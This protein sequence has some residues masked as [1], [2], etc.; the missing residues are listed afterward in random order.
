[1]ASLY[2]EPEPKHMAFLHSV[3]ASL[4]PGNFMS[5]LM[6]P[7]KSSISSSSS[8]MMMM[9]NL[10]M[11]TSW[12]L[13]QPVEQKPTPAQ[14]LEAAMRGLQGGGGAN[15]NQN[16]NAIKTNEDTFRRYLDMKTPGTAE[17]VYETELFREWRMWHDLPG[18]DLESSSSSSSSLWITG[19]AGAG[20][21]VMAASITEHLIQMEPE[22]PVLFFFFEPGVVVG[23]PATNNI[24]GNTPSSALRSFLA[25]L[26]PHS[27]ALCDE[28]ALL[29][30]QSSNRIRDEV[31][32]GRLTNGLLSLPGKEKEKGKI[33]CIIDGI[34]E[35][36]QSGELMEYLGRLISSFSRVSTLK[37]L[38][39]GRCHTPETLPNLLG[40]ATSTGTTSPPPSVIRLTG[41]E[42]PVVHDVRTFV[43]HQLGQFSLPESEAAPGTESLTGPENKLVLTDTDR[44]RIAD[45]IVACSG[46]LFL[47]ARL[48]VDQGVSEITQSRGKLPDMTGQQVT[49]PI[50]LK[51]M[52]RDLLLRA[53]NEVGCSAD[54]SA[55]LLG[56][57][58]HCLRPLTLSELAGFYG[59]YGK[60][61]EKF[62]LETA[63]EMVKILCGPLLRVCGEN[64]TV[65][66]LH[67]SVGEFIFGSSQT[68]QSSPE[69]SSSSPV[70]VL[71]PRQQHRT[72]AMMLM[73]LLKSEWVEVTDPLQAAPRLFGW[74]KSPHP[75]RFYAEHFWAEHLSQL[76]FQLQLRLPNNNNNNNLKDKEGK[77]EEKEDHEL[78]A[79][80]TSFCEHK[81]PLGVVT[82]K[83]WVWFILQQQYRLPSVTGQSDLGSAPLFVAGYA[84][85]LGYTKHLLLSSSSVSGPVSASSVSVPVSGPL[86]VRGLFPPVIPTT[87]GNKK[88]KKDKQDAKSLSRDAAGTT[89]EKRKK[90]GPADEDGPHPLF[91][92][93]WMACAR[94]HAKLA[95]FLLPQVIGTLLPSSVTG[96]NGKKRKREASAVGD[97]LV[98]LAG[99]CNRID[100][101]RLLLGSGFEPISYRMKKGGKPDLKAFA[102]HCSL[103]VLIATLPYLSNNRGEDKEEESIIG[104]LVC[105]YANSGDADFLRAILDHTTI[106]PD[107]AILDGKSALYLASTVR[108]RDEENGGTSFVST[109]G[110]RID[111]VRLLLERGATASSQTGNGQLATPLHGL[112]GSWED[113]FHDTA[114]VVFDMLIQAGADLEAK[115]SRGET[116]I[117]R[118]FPKTKANAEVKK[119][120]EYLLRAGAEVANVSDANGMNLLHRALCYHRNPRI[121]ELLVEGGVDVNAVV[122]YTPPPASSTPSLLG[123]EQGKEINVSPLGMLFLNP[124]R[125]VLRQHR[126]K[127]NA[128]DFITENEAITR[129]LVRHGAH[130]DDAGSEV[131]DILAVALPAANVETVRLLLESRQADNKKKP[132]GLDILRKLRP[133]DNNGYEYG[134]GTQSDPAVTGG[135]NVN[136]A[137]IILLLAQA[138]ASLEERDDTGRTLLL[139]SAH[140]GELFEGLLAAGADRNAVD[141]EGNGVLHSFFSR[142]LSLSHPA[143][144]ATR[145]QRLV[146]LGFDPHQLDSEGNTLLHVAICFEEGGNEWPPFRKNGPSLEPLLRQLLLEYKISPRSTNVWG[147]TP[148]HRFLEQ[149]ST[150][151]S[152]VEHLRK[153]D[154]TLPEFVEKILRILESSPE[155][156]DINAVDKDGLTPLHICAMSVCHSSA[157]NVG[158][159]L[160]HGADITAVTT[161]T[162]RNV[163]HHACGARN[164]STLRALV[165]HAADTAP[166][167]L[168]QPDESG[169]TPLFTACVSGV[170]ESVR[171]LLDAGAAMDVQDHDGMTALH[172]CAEFVSEQQ[173]WAALA[174]GFAK[175]RGVSH[176]Q[177]LRDR[178]R[179]LPVSYS[180]VETTDDSSGGEREEEEEK[181]EEKEKEDKEDEE[182]EEKDE[183]EKRGQVDWGTHL[184]DSRYKSVSI[185]NPDAA[186]QSVVER[187]LQAGAS[188]GITTEKFPVTPVEYA[189]QCRCVGMITALSLHSK[190]TP[191]LSAEMESQ[192]QLIKPAAISASASPEILDAL[193]KHPQRYL[194]TLQDEDI[195]WLIRNDGDIFRRI[196]VTRPGPEDCCSFGK[197]VVKPTQS[198]IDTVALLG[199]TTFMKRIGQLAR[200]YDSSASVIDKWTVSTLREQLGNKSSVVQPAWALNQ[201]SQR[202][203]V[204]FRPLIYRACTRPAPNLEMLKVLIEDCGVDPNA[205]AFRRSSPARY[206]MSYAQTALGY[207]AARREFWN[208]EAI[209]YLVQ[210]GKADVNIRDNNDG[211]TPLFIACDKSR[212]EYRASPEWRV[213]F[214][215]LLLELGAD[216]AI[217]N[218]N[219][220]K[221]RDV[222][223]SEELVDLLDSWEKKKKGVVN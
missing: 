14:N 114:V 17:W 104:K 212:V 121:V 59:L 83:Y 175:G 146:Q 108:R 196:K 131:D 56:C 73:D 171:V 63:K 55:F 179:P 178:F 98:Q 38:L 132:L 154:P 135:G 46:G 164:P 143:P 160:A 153:G 72:M 126:M 85:M 207:L 69:N 99:S 163:L 1:M 40:A 34:D 133:K 31:L 19:P 45:E 35:M 16:Q 118:L 101:L 150:H 27:A 157:R 10:K 97:E 181:E 80:I 166:F 54:M 191:K 125:G 145:L 180:S 21:S 79:A 106:N 174:G 128:T 39:T 176:G 200:Y 43:Q 194:S 216:P 198:F 119:A 218:K 219:G 29:A 33:V 105:I 60:L 66:L 204:D 51:E 44:E 214:V 94:G 61:G 217:P 102:Q 9:G 139:A 136:L 36:E 88:G 58:R 140:D 137:E 26:L 168:N 77:E 28:L 15:Q 50:T 201:V 165:T 96:G 86:P 211:E 221:C 112:V 189:L 124:Q 151:W 188:P 152:R 57:V 115:D 213:P 23:H 120:L 195:D 172:A 162:G 18:S 68:S 208:L 147:H 91:P 127:T 199:L 49:P 48:L 25:Q 129:I 209:R 47:C 155:G 82:F 111:C 67:P 42:P 78:F 70:T 159:L 30:R 3:A 41:E 8:S 65:R 12:P 87:A 202:Y 37:L 2:T 222:A 20:K 158:V 144:V 13:Q 62:H 185:E 75:L 103:P 192:F 210:Q 92:A 109:E 130:I 95:E 122:R 4:P 184:N 7:G 53:T 203:D 177:S 215:K 205:R 149:L 71:S 173:K 11:P 24:S 183:E 107:D 123:G 134:N 90:G 117:F 93:L 187:L 167:L 89:R 76:E 156:I 161:K 169:R 141:N 186:I 5:G 142:E 64:E 148:L 220:Q 206:F 138:G 52:Y 32:W 193:L 116:P 81:N 197:L 6:N 100:I 113:R 190:A 182:D 170:V 74:P 110:S 22:I 223:G 84:G